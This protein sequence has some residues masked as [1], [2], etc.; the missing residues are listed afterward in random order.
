MIRASI[1]S[2]PALFP[3]VIVILA[4]MARG[5]PCHAAELHIGGATTSITPDQPVAL[6]GRSAA[7]VLAQASATLGS[8][9]TS[10]WSSS[11][12]E[13]W[14]GPPAIWAQWGR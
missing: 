3:S 13:D 7:D 4:M 6:S 1:F 12:V 11:T 14:Q 9:P 10:E 2:L 5:Q 8:V